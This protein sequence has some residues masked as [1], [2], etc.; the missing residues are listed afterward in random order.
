MRNW[1]SVATGVIIVVIGCTT[2][3]TQ[4]WA[5]NNPTEDQRFEF[6]TDNGGVKVPVRLSCNVANAP[7]NVGVFSV[8]NY[9]LSDKIYSATSSNTSPYQWSGDVMVDKMP[10]DYSNATVIDAKVHTGIPQSSMTGPNRTQGATQN[11]KLHRARL[12]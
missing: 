8:L 7:N 11:I 5:I 2:T 10:P 1:R 6:V 9:Q 4:N 3:N 12:N